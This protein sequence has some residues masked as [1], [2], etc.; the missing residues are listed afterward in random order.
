MKSIKE[1]N[2][3]GK[4]LLNYRPKHVSFQIEE[5]ECCSRW[6]VRGDTCICI[7]VLIHTTGP[8]WLKLF[9]EMIFLGQRR[10]L[11]LT[12][13]WNFNLQIILFKE[14]SFI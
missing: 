8:N 7:F 11:E 4:R 5:T 9:S 3:Q 13:T 6:L 12:Q 1:T 10:V 2:P 14:F